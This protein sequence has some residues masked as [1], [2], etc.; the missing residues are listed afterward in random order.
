[1]HSE[2]HSQFQGHVILMTSCN[3]KLSY[4]Y[5]EDRK[6]TED[7]MAIYIIKTSKLYL[8]V[9]R[10]LEITKIIDFNQADYTWYCV[11]RNFSAVSFDWS[12]I[13]IRKSFGASRHISGKLGV[14]WTIDFLRTSGL[15]DYRM[16]RYESCDHAALP[17]RFRVISAQ[18]HFGPELL[19]PNRQDCIL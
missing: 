1:M 17:R 10:T 6:T 5:I 13:L 16:V 18:N 12:I 2:L 4:I 19:G 15:T 11:C 7:G 3:Y 14:K 8:P 9:V